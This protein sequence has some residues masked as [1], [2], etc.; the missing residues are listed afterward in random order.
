MRGPAG[1]WV[2]LFL[3]A[4]AAAAQAAAADRFVPADPH[5]VVANVQAALPDPQLRELIARWR[6]HSADEAAVVALAEAFLERAQRLREPMYIGRAEGVL[7]KAARRPAAS[8]TAQRLYA[9]TL[10]YRHDFS[11]AEGVLDGALRAAPH[12]AAARAQRASLRLVRGDFAGARADCARLLRGAT[13]QAIALACLAQVQAS[14]DRLAQAQSMLAA[15]PAPPA[16]D[17]ALRAYWL[18]VRGELHERANQLDR[19]IADYGAALTLQPAN[20]AIRA[21]LADAL[22]ARGEPHEARELLDVERPGLALLVR[23]A[24][25]A[26]GAERA[27]LRA[28]AAAWLALEAA[29]GDSIHEREAALL[30]LDGGDASQALRAA[31]ANFQQQKE[32]VD[33][34]L[35]ARAAVAASDAAA[36]RQLAEWLRST[37]FRDAVTEEILAGAA[38]G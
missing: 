8:S 25:C 34:R 33:V 27:K 20:D 13:G 2:A 21:T 17:G 31:R 32:L 35:L 12:D 1:I 36:R 37:G 22:V 5:F 16:H 10:Q 9:Q 18:T 26:R 14:S 28:Q 11:A 24:A 4:V 38:R 19:A 30:A 15:W 7:A 6:L 3:S 23:R 29:R